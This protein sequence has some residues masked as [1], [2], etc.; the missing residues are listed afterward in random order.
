MRCDGLC[1]R[2]LASHLPPAVSAADAVAA[3]RY[4]PQ[5]YEENAIESVCVVPDGEA[6]APPEMAVRAARAALADSGLAGP[7]VGLLLHAGLYHQ[8]ED[9]WTPANYVQHQVLGGTDALA[10]Q[11]HQASNGGM[12]ALELAAAY[13]TA[14]SGHRNALVT[15][16]DR[17]A[18][19]GFD[20][21]RTDTGVVY[22]DGATALVLGRREEGAPRLL[23]VGSAAEPDLEEMCRDQAG[24]T[25]APH[26]RD[27]PLDVRA[28][29]K[30]YL[31]VRGGRGLMDR[32]GRAAVRNI[33]RTLDEAG[34]KLDDVRWVV[35]PNIGFDSLE[36]EFLEPLGLTVDR[37][38]W[39]WGRTVGHLGAGDQFAGLD[40]VVRELPVRPGDLVLLAGIGIGF[41]WTSAVV[42]L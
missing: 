15:T 25:P 22:A 17:Y 8:G 14:S 7:D 12:A 34:A 23:A 21:W 1:V 29:K 10:V 4:L 11:V 32:L 35:L 18:P 5:D 36:W 3:G 20:R 30:S 26:F 27:G 28:R 40:H 13:L 2:G 38:L 33:G 42:E 37:T 16:A 24:F 31:R 41:N 39:S 9:F 19:P 6:Q